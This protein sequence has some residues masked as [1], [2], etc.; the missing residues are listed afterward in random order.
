MW[1]RYVCLL[2]LALLV[3]TCCAAIL[4]P[5]LL[6]YSGRCKPSEG[7]W[8]AGMYAALCL[9]SLGWSFHRWQQ[10]RL[11]RSTPLSRI[12]S[13]AQG[14]VRLSGQT[15]CA[16][17]IRSV[18]GHIAAL[19][20]RE[21]RQRYERWEES[22]QDEKGRTKKRVRHGWRSVPGTVDAAPFRLND[23]TD[24]AEVTVGRA[25]FH[26]THS[27]SF[28]NGRPGGSRAGSPRVGD[29]RTKVRYIPP[30]SQVTVW[31]RC[32][33]EGRGRKRIEY[34]RFTRC[35]LIVEGDPARIAL[36][37]IGGAVAAAIVGMLAGFNCGW[38]LLHP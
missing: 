15:S 10:G 22:Y 35:L 8:L 30:V 9:P 23:G 29:V 32:E 33:R 4:W 17:P 11:L 26:P 28:Y 1:W 13:A 7:D 19:Y 6:L 25:E 20:Y 36:G 38:Y 31:G 34:D 12:R 24:E 21:T 16:S 3:T 18:T 14:F 37:R 2:L 5:A 27:A